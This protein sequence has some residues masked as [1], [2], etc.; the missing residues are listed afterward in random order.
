MGL[1]GVM[2]GLWGQGGSLYG[3]MG[4]YGAAGPQGLLWG[5]VSMGRCVYGALSL[6][7]CVYGAAG[8]C[9]GA[10]CGGPTFTPP[11]LHFVGSPF[12]D[13]IT[14]AILQ[15]QE[16]NRLEILKRKWWEGGKCPKEEDHRA[17]GTPCHSAGSL[18]GSCA[19]ME[20][21]LHVCV[22][23]F[24]AKELLFPLLLTCDSFPHNSRREPTS[25]AVPHAVC[26]CLGQR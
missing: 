12:R 1:W 16:N 15:L 10:L 6:G 11:P 8:R 26:F 2:G 9:C 13:E 3:V 22:A 18:L 25:S 4:C 23:G 19:R 21:H 24:S 5:C 14:L 17:K 20:V 7:L